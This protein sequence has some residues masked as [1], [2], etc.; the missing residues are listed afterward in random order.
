[1]AWRAR[2]ARLVKSRAAFFWAEVFRPA[3]AR[4]Y[5]L[6]DGPEQVLIRHRNREDSFVLSEI[7]EGKSTYEIPAG[8]RVALGG[9]IR[10]ILDLGG[11]I[12]LASIWFARAFPGAR[13][14]IIE[15]DPTNADLLEQV[16]ALN[17]LSGRATVICAAAAVQAGTLEFVGGLGGRSHAA[18]GEQAATTRVPMI[19]V[20]PLLVD[21]D[22]LKMDIEGGEWPILSDPRLAQTS[23]RALCLEYHPLYCPSADPTATV[24]RLLDDAGFRIVEL[25][26]YGHS[27]IVWAVR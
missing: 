1:M 5:E 3:G 22:L 8:V 26:D 7:F 24:R 17:N 4:R 23:L 16:L 6:A 2:R 12:G 21:V 27:G 15:A 25:R 9:E 13:F 19:D 20:I 10:T 18:H 11:N 14:T